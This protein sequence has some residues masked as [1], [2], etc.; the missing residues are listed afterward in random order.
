MQSP[1][2]PSDQVA[3]M[4]AI[5]CPWSFLYARTR[6][7][8]ATVFQQ[9]SQAISFQRPITLLTSTVYLTSFNGSLVDVYS[10]LESK[11]LRPHWSTTSSL[12]EA[13]D[14][15]IPQSLPVQSLCYCTLPICD[16]RLQSSSHLYLPSQTFQKFITWT[17]NVTLV[18][19]FFSKSSWLHSW[20][21]DGP[22]SF[23]DTGI[24]R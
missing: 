19:I 4:A 3:F 18:V 23:E 12:A 21:F 14:F 9:F 16:T 11:S 6:H 17:C 1:P 7:D 2:A 8:Y 20:P 5:R 22:W 13:Q 10:C 24:I 15:S